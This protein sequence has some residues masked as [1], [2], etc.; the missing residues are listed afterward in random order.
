M[1]MFRCLKFSDV[2]LTTIVALLFLH[3]GVPYIT[4]LK[5]G[6][7]VFFAGVSAGWA[8]FRVTGAIKND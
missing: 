8:V 1:I 2:L 7:F 3:V 4:T 5:G 6:L